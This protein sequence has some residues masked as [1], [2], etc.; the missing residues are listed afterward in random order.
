MSQPEGDFVMFLTGS[1]ATDDGTHIPNNVMVERVCNA[2][3]R[4]QVYAGPA[5]D[6]SMQLG[7]VA[8]STLDAT[9]QGSAQTAMPGKYTESGIP[10]RF[11]ESCELRASASGFRSKDINLAGLDASE[12]YLQVGTIVVHRT[13]KVEGKTLDAGVYRAPKE[14]VTAYE[15]GLE[16]KKNDKLGE[17]RKYFEKAVAAY[18]AYARGWFQL[19]T[20][21]EKSHEKDAARTAFTRATTEDPG[22]LPPYLSLAVMACAAENWNEV[23]RA[24][25]F[26]L[27]LDPFRDLNGYT[28]ELD[29]FNFAEAYFYSGLAN[30]KIGNFAEAERQA[31]KAERLLGRSTELHLLLAELFARKGDYAGAITELQ[32]YLEIVPHADNAAEIRARMAELKTRKDALGAGVKSDSSSP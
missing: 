32:S 11:L 25:N 7:S 1:V 5:G 12:K 3:V 22:Y 23:I 6:F 28:V 20:V 4:Q 15:K 14:A 17:A 16:A 21:L 29:G 31:L 8:D 27:A 24:T 30:Y 18:P 9:A 19:G 2:K 26:I 10:R 13:T